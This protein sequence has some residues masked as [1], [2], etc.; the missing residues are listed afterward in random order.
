LKA[1]KLFA[2]L[3]KTSFSGNVISKSIDEGGAV[4]VRPVQ[5]RNINFRVC[6][7]QEE[8]ITESEFAG[9]TDDQIRI[10]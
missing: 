6:S 9:C 10:R 8:K 3:S 1:E 4:E 5:G 7:L 2:G